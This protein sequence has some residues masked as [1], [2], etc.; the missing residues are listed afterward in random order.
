M[1][2]NNNNEEFIESVFESLDGIKRAKASPNLL[3][4]ISSARQKN[5]SKDLS[6]SFLRNRIS[7]VGRWNISRDLSSRTRFGVI[8]YALIAVVIILINL[9][10]YFSFTKD[11]DKQNNSMQMK[12]LAGE[13]FFYEKENFGSNY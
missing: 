11:Y 8:G 9:F 6:S 4:R 3:E 13:Y 1:N 2:K 7:T 10:T 12:K 5:V